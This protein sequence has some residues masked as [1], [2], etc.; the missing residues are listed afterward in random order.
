MY[1]N[2]RA[3]HSRKR[4]NNISR[5]DISMG[6]FKINAPFYQYMNSY[7]KDTTISRPSY[8]YWKGSH[9]ITNWNIRPLFSRSEGWTHEHSVH[10]LPFKQRMEIHSHI[11]VLMSNIRDC[12]MRI[13]GNT[14]CI[15]LIGYILWYCRHTTGNTTMRIVEQIH[16]LIK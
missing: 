10:Q 1:V 14:S 3:P 8:L 12:N 11:F 13:P 9:I 2:P 4:T 7:H 5:R 6:R 15:I 16:A